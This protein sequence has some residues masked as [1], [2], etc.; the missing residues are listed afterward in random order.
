MIQTL[1][2]PG[3]C[4]IISLSLLFGG[5]QLHR[6]AFYV[7]V[8]FNVMAWAGVLSGVVAGDAA[9]RIMHYFWLSLISSCFQLYALIYSGHPMLAASCFLV[10]FFIVAAAAR[11]TGVLS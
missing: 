10:S 8:A 2:S 5:T 3:I 11:A 7:T 9:V 1:I 6:F 4:A